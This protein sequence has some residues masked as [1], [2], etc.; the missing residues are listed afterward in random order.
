MED[1][2]KEGSLILIDTDKKE[3]SNG[4]FVYKANHKYEI[5]CIQLLPNNKIKA[6]PL[7]KMYSSYDLDLNNI[8]I[9]GKAF[10]CGNTIKEYNLVDIIVLF[11]FES[12]Q[13][14]L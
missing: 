1:T 2:I 4:I 5:R 7:N 13:T 10:W 9:I 14:E 3:L 11:Q 6:I 8:E 12:S